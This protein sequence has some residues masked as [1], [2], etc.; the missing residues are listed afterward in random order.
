MLH[1]A[2]E[3][4]MVTQWLSLTGDQTGVMT[5]HS[6]TNKN[7]RLSLAVDQLSIF[8]LRFFVDCLFIDSIIHFFHPRTWITL[9][10][11]GSQGVKSRD[12]I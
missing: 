11:C 10:D 2:Q 3:S 4:V 12:R 8:D 7:A 9:L 1:A 5:Q 6:P